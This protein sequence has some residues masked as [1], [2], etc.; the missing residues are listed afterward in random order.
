[1]RFPHAAAAAILLTGCSTPFTTLGPE[2]GPPEDPQALG[3]SIHGWPWVDHGWHGDAERT[4]VLWPLVSVRASRS[5]DPPKT[6]AFLPLFVHSSSPAG[7]RWGLRPLFDVESRETEDGAVSDTDLLFPIYKSRTAPD[8]DLLEVRPLFFRGRRGVSS[9]LT[10]FPFWFSEADGDSSRVFALPSYY[11]REEKG[12]VRDLHLWPFWGMH[13]EGTFRRDWTLF[14]FFS[15]ARDPEKDLLEWDAPFPLVHYGT[16][17]DSSSVR[18]IPFYVRETAPGRETTVVFPFW[19]RERKGREKEWASWLGP[20]WID[21]RDGKR[22]STDVLWPLFRRE[23]DPKGW[24]AHLF[25]VLW[26]DRHGEGREYTHLW[27][28]YGTSVSGKRREVSTVYPFFTYGRD[29]DSW[30][31]DAPFPFLGVA[32]RKD[33]WDARAWPLFAVKN[34][35][36]TAKGEVLIVARWKSSEKES[37]FRV[38]WKLFERERTA[39]RT[40]T[41]LNP[42]FR[43]ETNARGDSHWSVLFG[44][45]AATTENDATRWRILWFL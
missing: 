31:L 5:G 36:K 15:L 1:M 4:D 27:P 21:V 12:E 42:L 29:E 30:S 8:E 45:L 34:R 23:R 25:P 35:G 19:A 14:P 18:V 28:L 11:R 10:V 38:L 6:D 39:E 13:A 7:V 32:S 17:R 40:K 22:N 16:S 33:G 24:S 44:L 2:T 26:L 37:D 9:W 41:A 20:V 43:I 3:A